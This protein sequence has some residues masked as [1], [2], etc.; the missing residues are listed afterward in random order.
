MKEGTRSKTSLVTACL[1]ILQLGRMSYSGVTPGPSNFI[2]IIVILV[3][4]VRRYLRTA[5]VLTRFIASRLLSPLLVSRVCILLILWEREG[6]TL[7]GK[8]N[9]AYLMPRLLEPPKQLCIFRYKGGQQKW[10]WFI[11]LG[12]SIVICRAWCPRLEVTPPGWQFRLLVTSWTRLSAIL[13]MLGPLPSV[14]RIASTEMFVV[15]VI[16]WTATPPPTR[17]SLSKK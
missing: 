3:L 16:L 15:R 8:S 4:W 11:L 10:P 9:L 14:R 6:L 17:L 5:T 2:R 7:P 13:S 1:T 12:R